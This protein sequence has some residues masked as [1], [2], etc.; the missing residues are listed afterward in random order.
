MF[1]PSWLR[2][3][4]LMFFLICTNYP[5]SMVEDHAASAGCALVNGGD[6]FV[7]EVDLSILTVF[8]RF[9]VDIT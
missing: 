8:D 6:V 5:S 7:H 4:L 3:E 9:T 2:I 1:Y